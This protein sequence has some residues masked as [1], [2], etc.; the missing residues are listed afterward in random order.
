MSKPITLAGQR[1][2]HPVDRLPAPRHLRRLERRRLD[3]QRRCARAVRLRRA[4]PDHRRADLPEQAPER[5]RREHATSR[6]TSRSR[7]CACI[8]TAASSALNYRYEIIWLGSADR[9]RHHRPEGRKPGPRREPPV[10]AVIRRRRLLL[11]VACRV[12]R[13][14]MRGRGLRSAARAALVGVERSAVAGGATPR[15]VARRR[16]AR[17]RAGAACGLPHELH[18]GEQGALRLARVMRR[19]DGTSTSRRTSRRRRRSRHASREVPVG[20]DRRRGALREE[21][22]RAAPRPV[23]V[24]EKTRR[25]ASRRSTATG[26]GR[27]SARR[28]S[29]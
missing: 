7:R 24:M 8:A 4:R 21:R 2:A 20:R 12:A 19:D 10:D 26:A 11:S 5:R 28:A 27:S 18:E 23:M 29:S 15:G 13:V 22:R 25:R 17:R 3:A 6:T 1:A 16:R 9:L 14:R